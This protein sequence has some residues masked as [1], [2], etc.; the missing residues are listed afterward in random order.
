MAEIVGPLGEPAST[1]HEPWCA[2]RAAWGSAKCGGEGFPGAREPRDGA[3]G[4]R[5]DTL[6]ILDA[7]L[8]QGVDVLEWATDDGT[9]GFHGNVLQLLQSIAKPGDFDTAT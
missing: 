5:S 3:G 2:W 4:A 9:Y 6:R 1:C 7:E 8:R